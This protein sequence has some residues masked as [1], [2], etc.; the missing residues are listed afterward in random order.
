MYW[1]LLP[2]GV[3][4]TLALRI[5]V[6]PPEI[7]VVAATRKK[8]CILPLVFRWFFPGPIAPI[9]FADHPSGRR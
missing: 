3:E 8:T 4:I 5:H 1:P 9:V 6:S 2:G 7:L